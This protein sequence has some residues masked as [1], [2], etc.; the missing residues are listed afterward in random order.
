VLD[1]GIVGAV[2]RLLG[3]G[4]APLGRA[5]AAP[6]AIAGAGVG[7]PQ[8]STMQKLSIPQ[9]SNG[10]YLM[11]LKSGNKTALFKFVKQE[12]N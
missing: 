11:R 12:N 8:W 3:R 9:L 10:I 2:A 4:I 6:G 1:A 5:G 7:L